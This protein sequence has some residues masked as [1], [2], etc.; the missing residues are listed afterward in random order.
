[1]PGVMLDWSPGPIF[2]TYPWSVHSDECTAKLG[3]RP[4][5]FTGE[6]DET[7]IWLRSETCASLCDAG[8]TECTPCRQILAAKPVND[9]EARANDAPPHT[10]YQYLSHAQLVKMVHSSADEKNALQLKILNLTR[11][12]ARTSRRISDHKR[13]LMALATHDVPRL[14]HLIRLAVKQGVGIDE[15]LRRIEDAAKRL[16]NVK[17]FSDSEKKFMRLIKRMAGRKAVYAMSKF[18]GLLSATT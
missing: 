3:H 11:Q 16:Y 4:D 9:L 8:T 5:R 18:L 14:H 6:G 10:P 1:C 13:L 17:S 2:T 12:V 7:R 15:I